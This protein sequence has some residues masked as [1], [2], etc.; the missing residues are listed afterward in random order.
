MATWCAY[1]SPEFH[2]H[3]SAGRAH[4]AD[5]SGGRYA[6]EMGQLLRLAV[7][8]AWLQI[9]ETRFAASRRFSLK[10]LS[11]EEIT[12]VSS[13]DVL[14][15]SEVW[16]ERGGREWLNELQP[17]LEGGTRAV[18]VLG[19]PTPA[20][21]VQWLR[22]G[23]S[24]V[25]DP[26]EDNWPATILPSHAP[27]AQRFLGWAAS[28]GLS[29]TLFFFLHTPFEGFARFEAG[30][31]AEAQMGQATGEQALADGL[32]GDENPTWVVRDTKLIRHPP[33]PSRRFSARVLVIEDDE[34][35]QRMLARTLGS[36]G[37]VSTASDGIEGV[38]AAQH[39]PYDVIVTDLAMPRLDGWG[40]LRRLKQHPV[41]AEAAVVVMSAHDELRQRLSAAQ[42]GARAW[43]AKGARLTGELTK[44]VNHCLAP[45]LAAWNA[46]AEVQSLTVSLPLVGATWLLRTM[47]ELDVSGVLEAHDGLTRV[48]LEVAEGCLV[49]ATVQMGSLR[50]TGAKA[51][52]AFLGCTGEATVTHLSSV[53][54]AEGAWVFE[55]L[56][57]AA[58]RAS[59]A[60]RARTEKAAEQVGCLHVVDELATLYSSFASN[61]ELAV[62]QALRKRPQSIDVIGLQTGLHLDDVQPVVV[63]LLRRGIVVTAA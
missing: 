57:E 33:T 2:K 10:P 38:L 32:D 37:A 54:K 55:R 51:L 13:D 34:A 11:P 1:V 29:G 50:Q 15:L 17:Q 16:Q 9:L 25:I 3:S 4:I 40:V 14:L 5:V 47:A 41:T 6:F 30:V 61:K 27:L 26:A 62:L 23:A 48:E 39:H 18:A 20:E 46:L 19:A 53:G 44:A 56:D 21:A 22:T 36:L 49:S 58:D 63:D 35:L 8:S 45:R 24:A 59:A 52:E 28:R 12:A 31:L 60:T 42:A 43:V 7:S